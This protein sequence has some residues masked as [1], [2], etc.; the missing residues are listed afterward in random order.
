M[1]INLQRLSVSHNELT[2]IGS[3]LDLKKLEYLDL[4]YNSLV[5]ISP[6]FL[7]DSLKAVLIEGN[8]LR[9]R[10]SLIRRLLDGLPSLRYIDGQLIR[11][12]S[13]NEL[14]KDVIE[15]PI[16]KLDEGF[17]QARYQESSRENL[18]NKESML[19]TVKNSTKSLIGDSFASDLIETPVTEAQEAAE[20]MRYRFLMEHTL[21]KTEF[22]SKFQPYEDRHPQSIANLLLKR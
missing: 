9:D 14:S 17:L 10:D 20:K 11:P 4:S 19:S 12:L 6:S 1:L 8:P 21:L 16:I 5:D 15:R 7:P 22:D 18:R 2:E 13:P 3:L